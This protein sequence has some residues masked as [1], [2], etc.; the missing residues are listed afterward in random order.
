VIG[1]LQNVADVLHALESDAKALKAAVEWEHAANVSLSLTRQQLQ[2]G[3]A[4][5]L[6]L[7][8]A[9]QAYQQ[10][11]I[12]LVQARA[13]RMIDTVALLQAL[14]GGWWH[15][16]DA[17]RA[18]PLSPCEIESLVDSKSGLRRPL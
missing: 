1:A 4:N 17:A 5:L 2:S 8:V 15:R 9:N 10:A 18:E 13:N 3:Y 12:N 14:G 6:T 16:C 11:A 7:L